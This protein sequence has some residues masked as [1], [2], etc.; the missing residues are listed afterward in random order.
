MENKLILMVNRF[1]KRCI[2]IVGSLIGLLIFA[3]VF[4]PIAI[5][6]KLV[7]RG[8]N[9]VPIKALRPYPCKST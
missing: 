7:Q 3:I 2:D 8:G 1:V 4:V 9:R 6:I 5:A